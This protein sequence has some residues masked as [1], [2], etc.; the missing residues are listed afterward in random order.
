MAGSPRQTPTPGMAQRP[1][2]LYY[3]DWLRVFTMACVFLY[4]NSRFYDSGDW[5]IKNASSS[6]FFTA[7]VDLLNQWMMPL[8]FVLSG[9]AAYYSMKSRTV[10]GF[11]KERTMRILLPLAT[12]G[13]F[14]LGPPQIYLER[15]THRQF[16]G[17]FLQFF[18]H[19]FEGLY[20]LGGNF[21][22]MGVH[23]WYLMLLFLFSLVLLPLMAPVGKGNSS[24]LTRIAPVFRRPWALLLLFVPLAGGSFLADAL[25]MGFTRQMGSWDIFSYLLFFAFGYILF[26]DPH[27]ARTVEKLRFVTLALG[28]VLPATGIMVGLGVLA[29]PPAGHAVDTAYRA[30]ASWCIVLALIGLGRRLLNFTNR[31][32]PHA[33]EAV[34]P[35][36][37]LHQPVIL[38]VGFFITPMSA[39][40]G[41][42]YGLGVVVSFSI[43]I[44]VYELLVSRSNM[45]RLIFGMKRL[46]RRGLTPALA[47]K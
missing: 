36:Y 39:P 10:S 5:H 2:R 45:L 3:V 14:V 33:N 30:L 16:S 13:V 41:L 47:R 19:Y 18:P 25:E 6:V 34:L 35:F 17:S 12:I 28:I 11:V 1:D 44:G 29:L 32:L 8:M 27:I 42:K 21:A 37:I 15:L 9:A 38:V 24:T 4:H 46:A 20:G 22:F 40:I 7:F 26:S 43:I 23:L 31:F